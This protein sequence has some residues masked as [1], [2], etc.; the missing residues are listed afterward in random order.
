MHDFSPDCNG[1]QNYFSCTKE[2]RK[3]LA[4]QSKIMNYI[5]RYP[6]T[7]N[8][9]SCG[10]GRRIKSYRVWDLHGPSEPQVVG[11]TG[12]SRF[13]R[14][15]PSKVDLTTLCSSFSTYSLFSFLHDLS[16]DYFKQIFSDRSLVLRV[17]WERGV[18]SLA[19]SVGKNI[20]V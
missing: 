10:E 13:R 19:C 6:A 20:N 2:S 8:N 12:S 3:T 4:D 18:F 15:K 11:T 16:A 7:R 17:K 5:T 9:R 1:R 14:S